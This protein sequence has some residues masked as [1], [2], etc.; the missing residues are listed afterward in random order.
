MQNPNKVCELCSEE[1]TPKRTD[2]KFCGRKC[3]ST[4][5]NRAKAKDEEYLKPIFKVIK[6]NR[7]ILKHIFEDSENI[8]NIVP[9]IYLIES[10]FKLGYV[11][12]F[13]LS[14]E[15]NAELH[16]IGDYSIRKISEDKFKV[17]K[18]DRF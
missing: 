8:D 11:T 6:Q 2:A 12:M 4:S 10:G 15:S 3:R 16:I 17:E 9:S 7:A 18:N 13:M 5:N 14:Q 1:F